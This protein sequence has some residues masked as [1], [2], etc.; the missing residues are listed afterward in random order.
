MMSLMSDG[1]DYRN[2]SGLKGQNISTHLMCRVTMKINQYE[3]YYVVCKNKKVKKFVFQAELLN[4]F[5]S[6][7][8]PSTFSQS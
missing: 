3:R 4:T 1:V 7:K 2:V 6:A 8:L 5:F